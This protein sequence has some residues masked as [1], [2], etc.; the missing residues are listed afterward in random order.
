LIAIFGARANV[1]RDSFTGEVSP[2]GCACGL[3]QLTDQ[4]ALVAG[5]LADLTH[6]HRRP[7]HGLEVGGLDAQRLRDIARDDEGLLGAATGGDWALPGAGLATP[8]TRHSIA[9]TAG[10]R[11]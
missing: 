4:D 7:W 2:D 8:G 5:L 10:V 9:A 11:M 3:Q 1:R 6:R